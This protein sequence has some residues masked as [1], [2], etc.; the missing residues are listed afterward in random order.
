MDKLMSQKGVF[1]HGRV[2]HK[3]LLEEYARSHIFAYPCKFVGEIN[4]IALTKAIACGCIAVTN[5]FAV[6]PERNPHIV[7]ENGTFTKH[8][9]DTLK[10][11]E[12]DN[13]VDIEQYKKDNSWEVVAKNW[14]NDLLTKGEQNARPILEP[15]AKN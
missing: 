13:K 5:D 14:S 3:E 12:F 7:S 10:A 9:I 11:K 8:L 2:G 6:L 15:A 4:C 1:E